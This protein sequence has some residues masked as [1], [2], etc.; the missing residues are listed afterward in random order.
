MCIRDRLKRYDA[1]L[2][3]R[4]EI[5]GMYDKALESLPVNVLN[6]FDTDHKSSGHLY[7]IR[8]Q[9]KTREECNEIITKIDVYK[10]QL[11]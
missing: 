8:V 5:I 9:G 2:A 3:R 11:Q 6:H 1:L 4:R 10:R 7:L